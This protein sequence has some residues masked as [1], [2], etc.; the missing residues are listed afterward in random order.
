M[1]LKESLVMHMKT[2]AGM[3]ML[4]TGLAV[5]AMAQNIVPEINPGSAV[6]ALVLLSGV[7]LVIRGRS[8]SSR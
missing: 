1:I 3:F 5:A 2:I 8:K 6:S 4:L 7:S